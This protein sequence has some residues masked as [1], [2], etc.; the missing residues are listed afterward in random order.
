ME[1]ELLA[2]AAAA[3]REAAVEVEAAAPREA[4]RE[5]AGE[6][7]ASARAAGVLVVGVVA[8]VISLAQVRVAEHLVGARDLGELVLGLLAVLLGDL[9]G[10]PLERRVAVGLLDL[11]R[12]GGARH[13][14]VL[15]VVALL[16]LLQGHLGL[17]QLL[18]ELF[19]A[20]VDLH[21]A[22]VGP[23]GLLVLLARDLHVAELRPGVGR[24]QHV[25]G[26]PRGVGGVLEGL[27]LDG[28]LGD[29]DERRP[30]VVLVRRVH[31]DGAPPLLDGRRVVPAVE[32]LLPLVVR[33]HELAQLLVRVLAALVLRVALEPLAPVVDGL[34]VLP[35]RVVARAA[36]LQRVEVVPLD[37][38][39]L[40]VVGNRLV[41]LAHLLVRPR[42]LHV[43]AVGGL[44]DLHRRT[45]VVHHGAPVP[46]PLRARRRPALLRAL[47]HARHL[48]EVLVLRVQLPELLVVRQARLALAHDAQH[49]RALRQAGLVLR[50]HLERLV[51]VI[52]RLAVLALALVHAEALVVVALV[53]R[54]QPNDLAVQLDG[55]IELALGDRRVGAA[56]QLAHALRGLLLGAPGR[57]R[58]RE[59]PEHVDHAADGARHTAPRAGPGP[60]VLGLGCF[61]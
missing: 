14:E 54:L 30:D 31:G 61:G 35:Q 39:H 47:P 21:G 36:V 8:G 46:G 18:L 45:Q 16:A 19:V 41:Q 4:A 42:A 44:G 13:A 7:T 38:Q 40:A 60:G 11:L 55:L 49:A 26:L 3:P 58:Q 53:A 23:H 51:E 9:V 20:P 24:L 52:E 10:V 59:R 32:G 22:A 5:A 2:A 15:V 33:L 12:G 29:E 48:P 1:V 25:D 37:L 28:R 27:A 43:H 56:A 50:L 34:L 17:V 57:R 6:A